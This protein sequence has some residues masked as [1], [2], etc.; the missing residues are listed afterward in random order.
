MFSSESN[1][2]TIYNYIIYKIN[3]MELNNVYNFNL[4]GLF[5]DN[6]KVIRQHR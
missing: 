4:V 6:K 3:T 2:N 5:I 1:I